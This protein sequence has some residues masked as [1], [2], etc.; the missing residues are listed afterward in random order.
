MTPPTD[1]LPGT[2]CCQCGG[3]PGEATVAGLCPRC[4]ARLA[5]G[6]EEP[7]VT[8]LPPSLEVLRRFGDYDLLEEIAR[9]GMG[10]VYRGR[11]RSLNREVAIKLLRDGVLASAE[12]ARRFRVEAA[13]VAALN[14]PQIVGIHEV[15]EH[16]GQQFF[17]MPLIRGQDLARLTRSGPLPA[18]QAAELVAAVADAVQHAH[19]RGVLHR[20]LKPSNVLVDDAGAPHVTDFGLARRLDAESSLTLSGQVVGTPG[21][22]SPE[23]ASGCSRALTPA[24]DIYGL[25]ALLYHLLTGRAPFVG[26]S[27]AAILRQVG[28]QDPTP[29]RLLNPAV[30]RDVETIALKALAHEPARRYPAARDV[31][32]ELQRFLRGEPIQARPAPRTERCWRW[33]RR[34]PVPA[35]LTAL[36]VLLGFALVATLITS[37]LRLNRERLR[38]EQ[39]KAFLTEVLASPDPSRD[40]RDVRVVALLE[41]ASQRAQRELA[42]QPRVLAEIQSTLGLT[43][44]QLSLYDEAEPLLRNALALYARSAGP[45]SVPTA[46]ARA[47]LGS[48]LV[49]SSRVTEGEAELRRAVAQLR[50]HQPGARV[51][52]ASALGELGT[53]LQVGGHYTNALPVL[54]ESIAL[55]RQIG[56]RADQILASSVGEGAT[57]LGALGR[58]EASI[59]Y[60]LEAIA[61]N[62]RIP[63]GQINLATCLSNQADW[64]TR[65][66]QHE[67]AVA[68]AQE[69]LEIR[70]RLF[71][72]NSSP[73]AFSHARLAQVLLA[74]TNYPAALEHGRRAVAIARATLPPQHQ[75][76]QFHLLQQGLALLRL[77]QTAEA[78]T[79]L[80]EAS[81]IAFENFG[82][83]HRRTRNTRCALAEALA[84]AGESAE[85]R[86][87]LAA[88]ISAAE[89]EARADPD[90]VSA[91]ERCRHL[92]TLLSHLRDPNAGVSP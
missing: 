87:L 56:S 55:C 18:R 74:S 29:P 8:E 49:W 67:S 52:L 35:I 90:L 16:E 68:A 81:L 40:G 4:L 6:P 27:P 59:A 73:V 34:H 24:S 22:L 5:F 30:P 53:A 20:D 57:V 28:V 78:V 39:V 63:D 1:Q 38:A 48:L 36:V 25:G 71:G 23:Q 72:T 79:T 12:D 64:H 66:G 58:R 45:A 47:H 83:G 76:L 14:H 13:V 31:R 15:G 7:D 44:Y 89:E 92:T 11:Q 65:L 46:E 43:Y 26:E 88:N 84:E 32:E 85:A 17:S 21:Y 77:G 51:E 82:P 75:D 2:A 19:D 62:R 37:N 10:V 60:N 80:R 86:D 50:R 41:R 9:G 91:Q 33:A 61:I 42:T 54:E 3:S 70:E 69:A